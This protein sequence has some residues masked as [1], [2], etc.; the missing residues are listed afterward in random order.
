MIAPLCRQVKIK[1]DVVWNASLS[2]TV[3]RSVFL[4]LNFV[5]T[6]STASGDE[7]VLFYRRSPCADPG[8]RAHALTACS[9]SFITRFL[10]TKLVE[11]RPTCRNDSLCP[12]GRLAAHLIK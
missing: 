1:N 7:V 5:F 12:T 3:S 6:F 8:S 11:S 10:V 2:D 4:V 9:P